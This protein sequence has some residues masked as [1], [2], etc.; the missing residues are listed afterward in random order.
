MHSS[1][2]RLV[3]TEVALAPAGD[4]D[5]RAG[6]LGWL[7]VTL[8]GQVQLDGLTLRLTANGHYALS[9]PAR[10]DRRGFDHAYIKPLDDAARTAIE[11]QILQALSLDQ[12]VA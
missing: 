5:T 9:F 1:K 10:R 7:A 4:A 12:G 2:A 11:R 6:L 3:I 8:N